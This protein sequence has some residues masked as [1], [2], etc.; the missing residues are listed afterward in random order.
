VLCVVAFV[1]R[2]EGIHQDLFGDE[3][4]T[5][6]DVH[7]RSIAGVVE[8]VRD[9]YED[10]PPLFFILAKLTETL[11]DPTVWIRVPSV[12][13]GTAL[14]PLVW[15]LGART[16]D[17]KAGFVAAAIVAVSPFTV[18]YGGEARAYSLLML[19]S[20][21]S[22]LVLLHAV[23]TRDRRWWGA[24]TIAACAVLYTHYTGPFV[25]VAQAAW[26]LW[27]HPATRV[28]LLLANLVALA[29]YGP[30][31]ITEVTKEPTYT[32]LP[33]LSPG[34]VLK[35]LA[36]TL[37]GHPLEPPRELPGRALLVAFG[38]T[39]ALAAVLAARRAAPGGAGRWSPDDRIVLLFLLL[40][41]VPA[42]GMI[43]LSLGEH[44]VLLPRSLSGS[45]P[46]VAILTGALLT[47]YGRAPAAVLTAAALAILAVGTLDAVRTPPRGTAFREVS[48]YIHAHRT[49]RDSLVYVALYHDPPHPLAGF[50]SVY[51]HGDG[52]PVREL[53]VNDGWAWR[54]AARGGR[55]FLVLQPIVIFGRPLSLNER[56]GPDGCFRLESRRVISDSPPLLLGTYAPRPGAHGCS[57][58]RADVAGP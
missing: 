8:R 22:T 36:Q 5:F 15:A 54:H 49:A 31:L 11:G 18:F 51:F 14:V 24:Y 58:A 40:A 1:L 23:A 53:G 10:N 12:I 35:T 33:D 55:V 45:I 38:V 3:L 46:A 6:D 30:W 37:P 20:A 52:M 48:S 26:A 43:V 17:R 27:V 9:G 19:C 56:E 13:A 34:Y 50:V 16:V 7:G 28:R 42:A 57:S 25:L 2:V 47:S 4:F 44:T 32:K 21:I 29:A 41:V 39:L